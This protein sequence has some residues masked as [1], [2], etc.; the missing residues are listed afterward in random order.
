MVGI[1]R[2]GFKATIINMLK[3][4]QEKVSTIK[5]Q[6]IRKKKKKHKEN[7]KEPSENYGTEIQYLWK[8]D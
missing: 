1:T 5:T 2:Q 8:R 4:L 7:S 3:N 6:D